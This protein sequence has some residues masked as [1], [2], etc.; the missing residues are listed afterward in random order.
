MNT[1]SIQRRTYHL[2]AIL[3]SAFILCIVAFYNTFPMTFNN[4]TGHYIN[5]GFTG[6]VKVDRP[7]TYG[8]FVALFSLKYSL[9]LILITHALLVA[10]VV[11][12]VFRYLGNTNKD[13][14]PYY[15]VFVALTTVFMGA[16]FEVA[17]LMPDVF[18]ALAI[19]CSGLLILSKKL[20]V[21]DL[22]I[23]SAITVLSIIV[24]NTHLY[25]CIILCCLLLGG[26]LF[27]SGRIAFA[28]SGIT[29]KKIFLVLVLAVCSNLISSSIHHYYGGVFKSSFGGPIFLMSNLV[30]MGVIDPYLAENC[31]N[32]DYRLCAYRDSI[33]N[34]FLWDPSS[35]LAKTGGWIVNEKEYLSIEK[36]LLTTPK[37][38]FKIVYKSVIYTIKLFFNYDVVDARRPTEL[39]W[40]S[41]ENRFPNDFSQYQNSLLYR[42]TI[43]FDFINYTQN[44]MVGLSL[45]LYYLIFSSKKTTQ[46]YL[47]L[48]LFLMLGVVINA[49]ICSTFSGV[50]PRYQ[51]RVAWI[52]PLPLFI[53]YLQNY[54]FPLRWFSVTINKSSS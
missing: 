42:G 1:I 24:H 41:V 47:C 4:D 3:F 46:S 29:V 26:Y 12:Y 30:E 48:F 31:E 5:S 52:I 40:R 53:Y 49:W 39:V 22:F 33:P 19:L 25:I 32:K 23:I 28:N 15:V 11:Y 44:I 50:Y 17:W 34:N 14:I 2:S 18:T 10:L 21:R 16:G 45:F 7:I 37:Y 36:D 54:S 35:P 43:N 8:V 38:L 20:K 51:T 13:Y 9:W 27:K 6:E